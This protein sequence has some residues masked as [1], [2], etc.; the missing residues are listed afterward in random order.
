M[1]HGPGRTERAGVKFKTYE[2]FI[3][4][5]FHLQSALRIRGFCICG[6]SKPWMENILKQ[7]NKKMPE[8]FK[9]QN[10]NLLAGCPATIYIAFTLVYNYLH[11]SYIVLGIINSEMIKSTREDVCRLYA[12]TTAIL[13]KGLEHLQILASGECWGGAGRSRNQSPFETKGRL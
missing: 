8:T 4:G 11:S 5:I 2:L 3:S 13:Y 6:F 12:N 7:T 9:K 10:L 1:I